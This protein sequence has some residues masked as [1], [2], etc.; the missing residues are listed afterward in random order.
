MRAPA[1]AA[2]GLPVTATQCWPCNGGFTVLASA[3]AIALTTS[4]ANVIAKRELMR[5]TE[6]L[7]F[8]GM[9]LP[10]CCGRKRAARRAGS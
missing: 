9:T 2:R 3:G 7:E 8:F 5:F 1:V 6:R 10:V 4:A